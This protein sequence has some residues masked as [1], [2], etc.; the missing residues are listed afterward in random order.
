ME[1]HEAETSNPES[2]CHFYW[3]LDLEKF[4]QRID[5][6]L[7][8]CLDHAE[9]TPDCTVFN[10]LGYIYFHKRE[11]GK[12]ER[13]F[14]TAI[15]LNPEDPVAIANLIYLY[16]N[17]IKLKTRAEEYRKKL[18]SLM[19]ESKTAIGYQYWSKAYAHVRLF[20]HDKALE[21]Y[22]SALE[23]LPDEY[24]LYLY[25]GI[26]LNRDA[27]RTKGTKDVLESAWQSAIDVLKIAEDKMTDS[28]EERHTVYYQLGRAYGSLPRQKSTNRGIAMDYFSKA[29]EA[30]SG[31]ETALRFFAEFLAKEKQNEAALEHFNTSITNNPTSA[32]Y[33]GRGTFYKKA[34]DITSAIQDFKEA[35]RLTPTN[36]RACYDLIQTYLEAERYMDVATRCSELPARISDYNSRI[37]YYWAIALAKLNENESAE[38]K[39]YQILKH[40]TARKDSK[41]AAK[42]WLIDYCQNQ[43]L[44][45]HKLTF[46]IKLVKLYIELLDFEAA[47]NVIKTNPDLLVESFQLN[48]Y[49]SLLLFSLNK[50]EAA[51]TSLLQAFKLAQGDKEKF[52]CYEQYTQ[53]AESV[54]Q[55]A[56]CQEFI[57]QYS[58]FETDYHKDDQPHWHATLFAFYGSKTKRKKVSIESDSIHGTLVGSIEAKGKR[59]AEA[60]KKVKKN[61]NDACVSLGFIVSDATL[62]SSDRVRQFIHFRVPLTKINGKDVLHVS[63][64]YTFEPP[65]ESGEYKRSEQLLEDVLVS[66]PMGRHEEIRGWYTNR[67]NDKFHRQFHCSERAFYGYLSK[68]SSINDIVDAIEKRY[69]PQTSI[70]VYAM[71]TDIHSTRYLCNDCQESTFFWYNPQGIFIRK[72]I[73]VLLEHG[74]K[75]QTKSG[76]IDSLVRVSA[77]EPAHGQTKKE[78]DQH[79]SEAVDLKQLRSPYKVVLLQ[80]DDKSLG[81]EP[82]S[83]F[84]NIQPKK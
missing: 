47:H 46:C 43:M 80:R 35:L 15:S 66:K 77:E 12:A 1:T 72:L 57:E 6:N 3:G 53:H 28:S 7:D 50:A 10:F 11:I 73:A 29:L 19:Q 68:E 81:I 58:K 24:R 25:K 54:S 2:E 44:G 9:D 17:E 14:Q 64:C 71:V 33:H 75:V 79:Q 69:P 60:E 8:R 48:Y 30:K 76:T 55:F 13:A 49:N 70:K 78:K 45:E 82:P 5:F 40:K 26:V 59:Q 61:N 65:R 56:A 74:H 67:K 27:A 32:A 84:T 39:Y 23:Y 18:T 21:L 63:D 36:Y 52:D 62:P 83:T 4:N 51:M 22:D 37:I 16:E 38:E 42:K 20:Q 34:G 31:D 41:D